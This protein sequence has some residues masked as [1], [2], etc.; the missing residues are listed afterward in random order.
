MFKEQKIIFMGT[1]DFAV[2]PLQALIDAGATPVAVYTQP[3]RPAG[4]GK[5]LRPSPVHKLAQ[6]HGIPVFTP[7]RFK[8]DPDAV[9][10][11]KAHQADIAVVAA[12]GLILPQEI[13]DA[14][15]LGCINIH[16]S[17][18][19]RWRGASPIQHAI[20]KGDQ[21]AGVTMMQMELGLDTGAMIAKKSI[22]ITDQMDASQLHDALSQ[23]GAEML[24]KTLQAIFTADFIEGEAQDDNLSSYAPMLSKQ[25]GCI[26]WANTTTIIDRQLRG[27][28]PWPGT[29]T[30]VKGKR[31]KIHAIT[32]SET[33][34]HHDTGTVINKEG[35]VA[36]GEGQCLRLVSVQPDGKAK[37]AFC[38]ALNGGYLTVGDKLGGAVS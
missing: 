13:L 19:P 30:V 26:N 9:T 29:W 27:L 36:C 6:E 21:E 23:I 28:T 31:L 2:R 37:M 38:D 33:Q 10:T 22:P 5:K 24:P 17:L 25:D 16:A 1:P 15:R 3:P 11:F 14:P 7:H 35:D 8:K 34:H 4:R 32:H 12:Y 20:W 18:L